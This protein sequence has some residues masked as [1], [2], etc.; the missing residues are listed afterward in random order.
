M[1]SLQRGFALNK[2]FHSTPT[3]ELQVAA[4]LQIIHLC[5]NRI[6]ET[7]LRLSYRVGVIFGCRREISLQVLGLLGGGCCI[8]KHVVVSHSPL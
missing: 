2:C 6:A 1:I 7:G 8:A 4:Y 5:R 3:F